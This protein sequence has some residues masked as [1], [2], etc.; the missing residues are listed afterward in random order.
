MNNKQV[1]KNKL[2]LE[3]QRLIQILNSLLI[4]TITGFLGFLG[5]YTFLLENKNKLTI[6]LIIS[7]L[8]LIIIYGFIKN[9]NSKLNSIIEE[10]DKL[11]P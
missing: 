1:E 10:I 7:T 9:I 6:G 5:S 8:I 11:K 3:Y 2:D 4:M